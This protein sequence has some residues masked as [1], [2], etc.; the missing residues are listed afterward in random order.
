MKTGNL[1]LYDRLKDVP[2]EAKKE[3]KGGRL[4]GFTDI[5]PMFRIKALTREFGAYGV[6]WYFDI[7]KDYERPCDGGEV[8]K[9]IEIAL[10]YKT[11][12]GWS[13]PAFGRG[14]SML[15]QME[16]GGLYVNDEASKMALTDAIGSAAKLLGLCADVYYEKDRTKYTTSESEAQ[17]TSDLSVAIKEMKAATTKDELIACWKKYVD[18]QRNEDFIQACKDQQLKVKTA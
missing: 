18:L 14:G 16:K 8:I 4:K 6:G 13:K 2:K 5:N 3:I 12:D 1:D 11:V 7:T 10:Y 15:V 17:V 9:E